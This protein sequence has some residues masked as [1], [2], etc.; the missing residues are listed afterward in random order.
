MPAKASMSAGLRFSSRAVSADGRAL[1][2]TAA[3]I[4]ADGAAITAVDIRMALPARNRIFFIPTLPKRLLSKVANFYAQ[5]MSDEISAR[6]FDGI[7]R[8]LLRGMDHQR[9]FHAG[10]ILFRGHRIG[11]EALE[12]RQVAGHAFEEEIHLARQHV[13]LAHF[14]PAAGALLEML[15]I[16]VLLAGEA[17]KDE[18]GDLEAQRLPVQLG[19]IALDEARLF[20]GA[21]AAQAGRRGDPG[22]A[23]QLDIG[24]AAVGLQ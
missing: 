18:A 20:Q 24:D 7:A 22:A 8:L 9:A 1:S 16:R 13:A 4:L 19:M 5:T 17:D 15:E 21:D 23:R 10:H 3:F 12:G 6:H 2:A 11:D 14:L